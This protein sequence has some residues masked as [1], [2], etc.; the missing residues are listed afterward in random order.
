LV[1]FDLLFFHTLIAFE[2]LKTSVATHGHLLLTNGLKV[3]LY[4]MRICR[5]LPATIE[6]IPSII[7]I[8][9][10]IIVLLKIGAR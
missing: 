10:P 5:V 3:F 9:V 1:D 4:L 2:I 8:G 6:K 7:I